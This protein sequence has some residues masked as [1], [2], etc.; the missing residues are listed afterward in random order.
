MTNNAFLPADILL[1]SGIDMTKWSVVACDQFTSERSYWD[2]V[3][4]TVGASPSTLK[5]IV[6]EAYLDETDP[7]ASAVKIGETMDTYLQQGLFQSLDSSYVYVERTVSDGQIRRGLV[8]MIDLDAYDYTPGADSLVRASEKTIVT[9]LPARVETRRKAPLE[10]PHIMA[11]INDA[12]LTVIEPLTEISDRL[13]AVYDFEL[14]ENGG[15]VRGWRVTGE[16]ATALTARLSALTGTVGVQ[17]V[18]GDGN[19]SL[20]AAKNLWDELKPS[21]TVAERDSPSCAVRAGRAEQHLR[22]VDRL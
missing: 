15:R 9:R 21:L 14:M 11:L 20:A 4:E 1:P 19:H 2:R 18:I 13:E 16:D 8:G 17:M 7:V 3:T 5:L 10:L 6:P 12:E 22:H